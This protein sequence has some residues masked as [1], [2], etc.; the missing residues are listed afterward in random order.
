MIEQVVLA[1]NRAAHA[2]DLTSFAVI[3]DRKTFGNHHRPIFSD[4][5][6]WAELA[7]SRDRWRR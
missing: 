3:H 5:E 6:E 2:K 4:S 7:A 1:R